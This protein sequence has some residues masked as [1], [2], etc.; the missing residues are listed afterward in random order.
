MA[1]FRQQQEKWEGKGKVAID[2]D[3]DEGEFFGWRL[4][5]MGE[6]E[7]EEEEKE[8][9]EEEEGEE[10]CKEEEGDVDRA[11]TVIREVG[12]SL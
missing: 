1:G 4:M 10:E 6:E 11:A 2:E 8:G 7:E 12:D 5:E 3:N 9:G